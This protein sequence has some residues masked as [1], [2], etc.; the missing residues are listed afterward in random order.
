MSLCYWLQQKGVLQL[1]VHRGTRYV[2]WNFVSGAHPSS[3]PVDTER[4]GRKADH[5][6]PSSAN[7]RM[8][9]AVPPL[10]QY[11]FMAWCSEHKDN[12]TFY[13]YRIFRIHFSKLISVIDK[14]KYVHNIQ[15]SKFFGVVY[16]YIWYHKPP[17]A[18][19][20][21]LFLRNFV[22]LLLSLM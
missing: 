1:G 9:G 10:P 13:L 21:S 12:F 16:S 3:Y 2:C 22:K 11:A 17:F 20:L 5:S 6:S 14:A 4:S 15:K 18:L 7:A 8:R 19:D